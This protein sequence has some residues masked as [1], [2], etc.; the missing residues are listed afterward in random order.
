MRVRVWVWHLGCLAAAANALGAD[1]AG[2][3]PGAT[4]GE[5]IERIAAAEG[6]SYA[7]DPSARSGIEAPAPA[8]FPESVPVE[9]AIRVIEQFAGL[10]AWQAEGVTLWFA[11]GQRPA[12]LTA[13]R[14]FARIADEPVG[15][16]GG[17]AEGVIEL[18]SASPADAMKALATAFGVTVTCPAGLL[19]RGR[20]AALNADGIDLES[21]V[22]ILGE[23]LGMAG[24]VADGMVVFAA[25][26]PPDSAKDKEADPAV[27]ARRGGIDISDG[28]VPPAGPEGEEVGDAKPD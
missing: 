23:S 15:R 9:T 1:G 13:C 24:T 11:S 22:A 21:A 28:L 12:L 25:S 4:L 19:E 10:E 27:D 16:F 5:A 17:Q 7:L 18:E 26:D 2:W 6:C 8:I 20:T 14:R 3:L